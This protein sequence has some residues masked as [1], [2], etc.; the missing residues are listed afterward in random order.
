MPGVI[1]LHAAPLRQAKRLPIRRCPLALDEPGPGRTTGREYD[2]DSIPRRAAAHE[3]VHILLNKLDH[4]PGG[5]MRDSFD[6]GDWFVADPARFR[7]EATEIQQLRD[8]LA[9]AD[10]SH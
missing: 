6:I 9:N 3:M 10:E 7:L 1:K 5:L 4:T 2:T 8:L